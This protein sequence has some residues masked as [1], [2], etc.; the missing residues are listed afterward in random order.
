MLSCPSLMVLFAFPDHKEAPSKLSLWGSWQE[1][2]GC[3]AG[4]EWGRPQAEDSVQPVSLLPQEA[5]QT[6]IGKADLLL[7][8]LRALKVEFFGTT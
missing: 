8:R 5:H 7:G 3:V 6:V 1:S 4:H 2:T